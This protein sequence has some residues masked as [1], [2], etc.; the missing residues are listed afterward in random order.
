[1]DLV[2]SHCFSTRRSASQVEKL[3]S[4]QAKAFG[5]ATYSV[6]NP[7]GP[8]KH[9]KKRLVQ[10]FAS[11]VGSKPMRSVVGALA[12]PSKKVR[13]I[14]VPHH[15]IAF[16]EGSPPA[17]HVHDLDSSRRRPFSGGRPMNVHRHVD[18]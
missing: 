5:S 4:F 1:M 7:I 15:F 14:L 10:D 11:I 8:I 2:L 18:C 12:V 16:P 17:Q 13:N 6:C 3:S 9:S